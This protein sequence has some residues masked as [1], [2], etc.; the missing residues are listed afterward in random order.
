MAQR[1]ENLLPSGIRKVNEKA[2][3]LERSGE[4]IIHFEIGRPDFDT[5]ESI[6]TTAIDSI[7]AG[8]VFYTSN[9]G[10]DALRERNCKKAAAREQHFL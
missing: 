6:K 3:A 7:T 9:Y 2:M 1:V 10:R 8:D 4:D 5:P